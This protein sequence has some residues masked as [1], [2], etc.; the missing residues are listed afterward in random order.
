MA[1]GIHT[2]CIPLRSPHHLGQHFYD[3]VTLK[4]TGAGAPNNMQLAAFKEEIIFYA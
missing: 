3:S 4:R 2:V 1:V